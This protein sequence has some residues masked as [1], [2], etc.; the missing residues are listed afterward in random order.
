MTMQ[1]EAL[2]L[3]YNDA[4]KAKCPD[5]EAVLLVITITPTLRYAQVNRHF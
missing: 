3:W 2:A 5:L 1:N 4:A